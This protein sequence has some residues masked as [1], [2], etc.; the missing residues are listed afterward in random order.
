MESIYEASKNGKIEE[1]KD[2]LFKGI[3][4]NSKKYYDNTPLHLASR[5]GHLSCV[6]SL[7]EFGADI[8]SKNSFN[9]TAKEDVIF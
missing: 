2:L 7:I 9:S 6:K 1:I 4:V 8:L 3:S 5:N